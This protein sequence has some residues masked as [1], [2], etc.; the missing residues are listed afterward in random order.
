MTF[1]SFKRNKGFN[2]FAV[3]PTELKD[4]NLQNNKNGQF[5]KVDNEIFIC[6]PTIAIFSVLL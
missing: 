4:K 5:K 1:I 6:T 3:V 2:T